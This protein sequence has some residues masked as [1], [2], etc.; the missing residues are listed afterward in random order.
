MAGDHR[1]TRQRGRKKSNTKKRKKGNKRTRKEQPQSRVGGAKLEDRTAKGKVRRTKPF[2]GGGPA[3]PGQAE[4]A[5]AHTHGTRAWRP[6]TQKGEVSASTQNSA[7]APT[8]VPVERWT[9]RETGRV[10]DRVRTRQ[11]TAVQAAQDQRQRDPPGTTPTPGPTRVGRGA[12]PVSLPRQRPAAST[13]SPVLGQHP[14][15][16]GSRPVNPG[17]QALGVGKGTTA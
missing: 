5:R 6:L 9:V 11:P 16:P 13:K 8:K 12:S 15:A 14:R 17:A 1:G 3:Q 7:G 2:P 4:H 10:S